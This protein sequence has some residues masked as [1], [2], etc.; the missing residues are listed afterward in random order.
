MRCLFASFFFMCIPFTL[1]AKATFASLPMTG[2]INDYLI[3][4]I[5]FADCPATVT[6]ADINRFF[7][8]T[9]TNVYGN[10]GSIRDY[11]LEASSGKLDLNFRVMTYCYRA[12]YNKTY[13]DALADNAS[14]RALALEALDDLEARGFNYAAVGRHP[15]YNRFLA[16]FLY[17]GGSMFNSRAFNMSYTADGVTA[18]SFFISNI[19][20]SPRMDHVAHELGHVM[21]EWTDLYDTS[22]LNP[23]AQ[24]AFGIGMYCLM[25]AA[26]YGKNNPILPNPYYREISGWM[27]PMPLGSSASCLSLT[28]TANANES[29]KIVNPLR[30][31]EVF[32]IEARKKTGRYGTI[33][34]EGLMIWHIDEAMGNNT[35][36]P[37]LMPGDHYMVSLEQADGRNDLEHA[38]NT[39][40]FTDIYDGIVGYR[41][42]DTSAPSSRWWDGTP[43]GISIVVEGWEG[44]K[45]RFTVNNTCFTS[46]PTHTQTPAQSPTFTPTETPCVAD[47]PGMQ[48]TLAKTQSF[49]RRT[50][51]EAAVFNGMLWFMGGYYA[52][53]IW[54]SSDG[55]SWELAAASAQYPQLLGMTVEVMNNKMY[56]IGGA[57]AAGKS[58][59][60]WSSED[61][62]N[63]VMETDLAGFGARSGHQ[64]VVFDNKLWVIGGRLSSETEINLNDVWWSSDGKKWHR[65]TGSAG[66]APR[67]EFSAVVHNGRIYVANGY[68]GKTFTYMNDVW[69]SGDG[70]SWVNETAAAPYAARGANAL[71]SY[72]GSMYMMC[73]RSGSMGPLYNDVWASYDGKTWTQ[74]TAAAQFTART[75]AAAAVF[76]GKIWMAGGMGPNT[77]GSDIWYTPEGAVATATAGLTHTLTH[78][79][80]AVITATE[81]ATATLTATAT[82]TQTPDNTPVPTDTP[83]QFLTPAETYTATAVMTATNTVTE[84]LAVTFTATCTQTPGVDFTATVTPVEIA[85]GSVFAYPNPYTPHAG[86]LNINCVLDGS[87]VKAGVRVYSSAYRLVWDS[88]CYPASKG[89]NNLRMEG[90][91]LNRLSPGTYYYYVYSL[92]ENGKTVKSRIETLIVLK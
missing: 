92:Q 11:F 91:G 64:S 28:L 24:S 5:D 71:V 40:D 7:N 18:H 44:E 14:A 2:V 12:K 66:F 47:C 80:T 67:K 25:G 70:I 4:L 35:P 38:N 78:T 10:N 85:A 82:A 41:F 29:Y 83:T 8:E 87:P 58:S 61:G 55:I 72:G 46:T 52:N 73:G 62:V 63:W 30:P 26:T 21:T 74:K 39:G 3:I 43:S 49:F 65:A 9:G 1:P 33:M 13:Y 79:P 23:G 6:P 20:G 69:S 84:G 81:T 76:A 75:G 19:E 68:D 60:V 56:V 32:Y 17:A 34:N 48:W 53:D 16:G 22:V 36:S 51:S 88:G 59:Q 90:A 37:G 15:W 89:V 27:N 31:T 54:R 50:Y 57:V 86:F 42:D 45:M 77:V